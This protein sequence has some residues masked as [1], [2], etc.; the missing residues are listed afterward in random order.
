MLANRVRETTTT[1]GLTDFSLAGAV[2]GWRSFGDA[3]G[4]GDIIWYTC[5]HLSANEWEIGIG[6]LSGTTLQRTTVVESSNS[7][8]KVSFSAGTKAVFVA[9]P[10][11]QF[12]E[13][14]AV[15]KT[16]KAGSTN[17]YLDRSWLKPTIGVDYPYVLSDAATI[18][19]DL[20]VAARFLVTIAGNRTITFDNTDAG[21][22]YFTLIVRQDGTGGRTI[23]W[24]SISW[25]NANGL[26]SAPNAYTVFVFVKL[27][28]GT[29]LGWRVDNSTQA[30]YT[31]T[32]ASS[33]TVSHEQGDN[34]KV[35]LTGD[36]TI[37]ISIAND[38][39]I[40]RLATI[41]DGTGGHTITWSGVTW[42]GG[43]APS[44]TSTAGRADLYEF[45]K[46]GS[47]VV[48][49]QLITNFIP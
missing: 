18:S 21:G 34:H 14:G 20:D 35:T 24:P 37:T 28:A 11:Q 41:Q 31:D 22:N 33:F 49:R 1:S 39:H 30:Y 19:V 43:S 16:P 36:P 25:Q 8:A 47:T 38:G 44:Q 6:T 10:S 9:I 17:I 32:Y 12:A 23:T 48:G 29:Y 7:D 4:D 3:F 2:T 13:L 27:A 42:S 40:M 5:Y 15:N 46:I 26:N 45:Q